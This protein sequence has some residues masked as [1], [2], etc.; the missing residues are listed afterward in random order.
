LRR[1]ML[2]RLS[3]LLMAL[4]L[5]GLALGQT[6][7]RL[8]A[9]AFVPSSHDHAAVD[10]P[11]HLGHEHAAVGGHDQHPAPGKHAHSASGCVVACCIVMSN[12]P[13][14]AS[15]GDDVDFGSAVL[16]GDVA[17]SGRG[18]GDAPEPGVPKHLT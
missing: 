2:H 4:A 13:Q 3:R 15:T 5:I 10:N 7:A 9:A 14:P 1:N 12:W 8:Q 11:A 6:G 16:Y 17:Q 18:R